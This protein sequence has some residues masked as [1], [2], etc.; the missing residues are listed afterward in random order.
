MSKKKTAL[1]A[2][3][4]FVGKVIPMATAT[5]TQPALSCMGDAPEVG[6]K[7]TMALANGIKYRGEVAAV[8][9]HGDE[10]LIEFTDG[11]YPVQK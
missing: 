3:S 2:Q 4:H 5:G 7:I 10:L 6:S 9:A 1:A 11:I 8:T